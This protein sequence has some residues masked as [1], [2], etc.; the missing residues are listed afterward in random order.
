MESLKEKTAKGLFWGGMTNGIQQLLG[1]AAGIILGRL[2]TPDDFGMTAM[3]AVFSVV[4]NELQN[5]GFRVA[6]VNM[7]APTANDYNSVFWFNIIMGLSMYVIL[8]FCAPLIAAYYRRPELVA[9]C[10]Y[11]FLGF[12][13]SAFGTAQ[14]AY[15][16]K[17]LCTKEQAKAGIL[18]TVVSISVGVVMAVN[19]WAYWSL[20]TQNIVFIGTNTL[21]LWY[22]SPW[23]PSLHIDFG[24]VKRMYRF[25]C[26]VFVMSIFILLNNNVLNILLGRY[27]SAWA[28]GLYSQAYQWNSKCFYLLQGMVQVVAQPVFV[29]LREESGRQLKALRKLMRFT[30]FLSFPMLLGFGLVSHEFIVIPLT[31]KWAESAEYIRILCISG[32]LVP[33]TSL[34]SNLIMSKGKSDVCMWCTVCFG[35]L[36]IA[37]MMVVYPYGIRSMV[38]SYVIAYVAWFFVWHHFV[39][40]YTG[41]GLFMLLADIVPYAFAAFAVM[42]ATYFITSGI[43]SLWGLLISKI[44]LAATLYYLLLRVAGSKILAECTDFILCK[45]RKK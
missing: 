27:F 7:K 28:T 43:S 9:L 16:T 10:R 45:I 17:N 32:A 6:L 15:L 18:A 20:A 14:L 4:A 30:A 37:L 35:L 11:A 3:I 13:F 41:Y 5:S 39:S 21:C 2:L 36:Q 1:L 38:V 34:F 22:Y 44:L 29:D 12:V 26:K 8:F 40:R 25:S 33:L 31:E 23:R 19:G 24:P 42:A